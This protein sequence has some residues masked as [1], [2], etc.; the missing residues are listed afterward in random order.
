[1]Q[2]FHKNDVPLEVGIFTSQDIL[3]ANRRHDRQY[4]WSLQ[5]PNSYTN[6]ARFPETVT[7][8]FYEACDRQRECERHEP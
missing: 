2:H 1:M 4:G 3:E 8:D 6:L 5:Q 7:G